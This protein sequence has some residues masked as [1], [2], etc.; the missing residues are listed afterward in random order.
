MAGF[1]IT[2]LHDLSRSLTAYANGLDELTDQ[3]LVEGAEKITKE[4]KREAEA[5]GHRDPEHSNHMIDSIKPGKPK[6]NKYGERIIDVFPRGNYPDRR[7]GKGRKVSHAKVAAILNYGQSDLQG[8]GFVKKAEKAAE[9]Q[10]QTLEDK[11]L[12][13]YTKKKGLN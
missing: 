1:E 12:D 2:G 7:D 4:W 11:F 6:D 10:L 8:S 3:L 13:E 9:K 5:A